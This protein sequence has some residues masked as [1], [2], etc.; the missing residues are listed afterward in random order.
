[1]DKLIKAKT[2]KETVE[3]LCECRERVEIK[4]SFTNP[5]QSAYT[6]VCPACGR[7]VVVVLDR[8]EAEDGRTA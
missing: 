8:K 7:T 5:E 3:V 6:A 4:V 1:M 2:I